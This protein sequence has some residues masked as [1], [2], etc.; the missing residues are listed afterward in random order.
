MVEIIS[1]EEAVKMNMKRLTF[2]PLLNR[3]RAPDKQQATLRAELSK[4]V[5]MALAID[6]DAI[7]GYTIVLPPEREERWSKLPFVRTLGVV[8]VAPGFRGRGIAKRLVQA[9]TSNQALESK[10]IISLEYYWHWDLQM[11]NGD[12]HA[13]K[14]LLKKMLQAS[15]FEDIPTNEPDIAGYPYNFM[16]GRI[17]KEVA[18]EELY[19][20]MKLSDP[21]AFM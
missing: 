17:G 5:A 9:V 8:E 12:A 11:T 21:K 2:H 10:I 7:I 6:R 19:Q 3:F 14:K 13:Y 16:M 15:R 4:E 1:N 18:S 20:F